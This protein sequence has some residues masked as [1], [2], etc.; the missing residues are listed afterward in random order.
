M[1]KK[2]FTKAGACNI[3]TI[4][5]LE[6]EINF[7][8]I[9]FIPHLALLRI[10]FSGQF[11]LS[12]QNTQFNFTTVPSPA[13]AIFTASFLKQLF[14]NCDVLP[15]KKN[16]E[17]KLSPPKKNGSPFLTGQTP[18]CFISNC[19]LDSIATVQV[20]KKKSLET[21]AMRIGP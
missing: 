3:L 20:Q 17:R 21:D 1:Q 12:K 14:T 4:S 16:M 18:G 19:F 7:S 11:G 13:E 5:M 10:Y 9:R 2:M 8:M 15:Q 6:L